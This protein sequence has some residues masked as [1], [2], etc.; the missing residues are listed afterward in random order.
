MKIYLK[1]FKLVKVKSFNLN[2]EFNK[3]PE[4]N[5]SDNHLD[6]INYFKY[7]NSYFE[8]NFKEDCLLNLRHFPYMYGPEDLKDSP[9]V[10]L[11]NFLK[12]RKDSLIPFPLMS[13]E[14]LILETIKVAIKRGKT[15][16]LFMYK[17]YLYRFVFQEIM[18][19]WQQSFDEK[20]LFEK[21]MLLRGHAGKRKMD[22]K[23]AVEFIQNNFKDCKTHA[24]SFN[25]FL[26]VKT[27]PL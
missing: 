5:A 14:D 1:L 17:D 8:N 12:N 27:L 11:F 9:V 7:C 25:D 21:I 10:P 2:Q 4:H 26:T 16:D 15:E 23:E 6:K 13:Q 18:K 3:T 24:T 22:P 19:D 20:V